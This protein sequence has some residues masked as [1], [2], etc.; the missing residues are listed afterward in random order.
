[1]GKK[2]HKKAITPQP[3]I[4]WGKLKLP[5]VSDR[6]P[7]TA[8]YPAFSLRHTQDK[9]CISKC[10]K[11]DKAAFADTIRILSAIT[12]NEMASRGRHKNGYESI[13]QHRIRAL[14]PKMVTKD[15]T[16]LAFRWSGMKPMVGFR[17]GHT[18]Y[19]LWFDRDLD[20]YPHS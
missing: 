7:D 2:K 17:D 19:V 12:W 10:D 8:R 1:M 16:L 18:F 20:L 4:G 6:L 14:I 11:E 13:P 3:V 5:A 15:T 9:Y